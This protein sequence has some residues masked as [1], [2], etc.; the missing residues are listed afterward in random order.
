MRFEYQFVSAMEKVFCRTDFKPEIP[1]SPALC[2]LNGAKNMSVSF[3]IMLKCDFNIH[4]T[5][6]AQTP[7]GIEISFREVGLVPCCMPAAVGNKDAFTHDPGLF[8]DP[9]IPIKKNMRLTA[10]CWNAVYVT[11]RISPNCPHGNYQIPVTIQ[12]YQ[13]P[14]CP[15]KLP[16][17]LREKFTIGL[18]VYNANINPQKLICTNWFHCDC[19]ACYYRTEIWSD[20]FWTIAANY[21]QDMAQHGRNMLYTPL[22]TPPLDTAIGNERPITQLLGICRKNNKFTFDFSRLEKFIDIAQACGITHFEMV[23]MFTQWGAK[24]TPL[25][26]VETENGEEKM[27]GWHVPADSPLYREFLNSL[28]PE[29]ATFLKGKNLAGKVYFHI[30]DEPQENNLE[31]YG[32]AGKLVAQYLP[33]H[34]FSIMDALSSAEFSGENC[35]ISLYRQ[36]LTSTILKICLCGKD[37]VILR[38]IQKVI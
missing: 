29:L 9:L 37:G 22:W 25:I 4:L 12:M 34:D 23:H 1:G 10:D 16:F 7:E 5:F 15:W 36:L 35:W 33:Q 24:A 28:L 20:T 11:L 31:L 32:A 13:H 2:Q 8:P 18:H 17:D 6:E 19:L 14:G 38:E 26:I 27:F 21:W 30:S 3:Q